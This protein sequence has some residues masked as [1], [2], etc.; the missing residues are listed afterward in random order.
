MKKSITM[1]MALA[2]VALCALA[3]CDKKHEHDWASAFSKNEAGHWYACAGCEEKKDYA[4]H[5][6]GSATCTEKAKC[7]VCGGEYGELLS[8]EY[9]V[10]SGDGTNHW[11]ECVCGAK[12]EA[13]VE[14]HTGGS[15]TC[16]QYATCES[17]NLSYGE[18]KP[19]DYDYLTTDGEKYFSTCEC[20]EKKATTPDLEEVVEALSEAKTFVKAGWTEYRSG[21]S[22]TWRASETYD[23]EYRKDYFYVRNNYSEYTDYYML[24]KGVVPFSVRVN[25]DGVSLNP[26]EYSADNVRGFRFNPIII[27]D[28]MSFYGA[29]ELIANLY[30]EAY[31]DDNGDLEESV[32]IKDGKI[33]G[34]FSFGYYDKADGYLF[35]LAVEFTL[36]TEGYLESATV[37]SDKYTSSQFEESADGKRAQPK[38]TVAN[39][40]YNYCI[41]LTQ[42]NECDSAN[43]ENPYDPELVLLSSFDLV[44]GNG[45]VLEDGSVITVEADT[46]QVKYYIRNGAPDTA[47]AALN[48]FEA[49]LD[50][51]AVDFFDTRIMVYYSLEENYVG[52]RAQR[53]VGEFELAL[54]LG[55][56]IKTFTYNVI[57][58]TPTRISPNV[59]DGSAYQISDTAKTYAGIGV[60]FN[61]VANAAYCDSSFTAELTGDN[62]ADASLM[63]LPGGGDYVFKSTVVG[64]Y[65]VTLTSTRN[66]KVKSVLTVE[67][68]EIPD[69][70]AILSGE[71]T[72][73]TGEGDDAVVVYTVAFTPDESA[74]GVCGKVEITWADQG[75]VIYNYTYAVESGL[76]LERVGGANLSVKIGLSNDFALYVER[77]G[78][79]YPISAPIDDEE[80]TDL[81]K[82]HPLYRYMKILSGVHQQGVILGNT[83]YANAIVTF[84]P[85]KVDGDALVGNL[86][87]KDGNSG[88]TATCGYRFTE[89]DG[90][91][92]TLG[93]GETLER[94]NVIYSIFLNVDDHVTVVRTGTV[95]NNVNTWVCTQEESDPDAYVRTDSDDSGSG[96]DGS[97]GGAGDDSGGGSSAEIE[98]TLIEAENNEHSPITLVSG[99]T[100]TTKSTA[101]SCFYFTY[102]PAADGTITLGKLKNFYSITLNSYNEQQG[103]WTAIGYFVDETVT[104]NVSLFVEK[105]VEYRIVTNIDN[106]ADVYSVFSFTF[107]VSMVNAENITLDGNGTD[108]DPFILTDQCQVSWSVPNLWTA[109]VF[110]Y[111]A[112]VD[113]TFSF[114]NVSNAIICEGKKSNLNGSIQEGM[115]I[116]NLENIEMKSGQAYYFIVYC[117]SPGAISFDF[118][119]IPAQDNAGGAKA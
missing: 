70:G 52:V 34:A 31:Y 73:V 5:T 109:T 98:G 99:T 44:D 4:E 1:I 84:K 119:M 110:S 11:Y 30:E 78:S 32:S 64:T 16:T 77:D 116:S 106:I 85:Q 10:L 29:E 15:A 96:G 105:G 65:T 101:D 17:C 36:G 57:L 48:P 104:K 86:V 102:T 39:A 112:E 6:G 63:L 12:D 9:T 88:Y 91:T 21:S 59:F 93:E 40:F 19:H 27:D 97:G 58:A 61:A 25:A 60:Q 56:V 66:E 72:Y 8:H 23:Y 89:A 62:A 7:E 37:Y 49:V 103:F 83:Y 115:M 107:K 13:T 117:E 76:T 18:L 114:T 113:G 41:S 35:K 46:P 80:N 94:E 38:A 90:F 69:V 108:Y 100:Y 26:D 54:R 20:G 42:T 79:Q 82:D 47:I 118:S 51:T 24:K 95:N 3:G 50:G 75:T 45:N 74:D 68:K 43:E 22:G 55:D 53:E 28:V 2:A 67:V 33:V 14:A 81:T 92:L 71:Y 111:R 87:F